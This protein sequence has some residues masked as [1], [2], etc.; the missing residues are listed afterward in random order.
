M[1]NMIFKVKSSRGI[2]KT[3][4]EGEDM[5]TQGHEIKFLFMFLHKKDMERFPAVYRLRCAVRGL[6]VD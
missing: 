6:K 5:D 1:T 4:K 2:S 3:A